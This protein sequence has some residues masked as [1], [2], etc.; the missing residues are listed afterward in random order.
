MRQFANFVP[1]HL[2]I[3]ANGW[4][5]ILK[6]ILYKCK[7]YIDAELDIALERLLL[8]KKRHKGQ[9]PAQFLTHFKEVAR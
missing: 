4:D 7:P 1:K 6:E 3:T 9:T 5:M 8:A 2:I